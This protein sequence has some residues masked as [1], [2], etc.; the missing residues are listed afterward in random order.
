VTTDQHPYRS[1]AKRKKKKR[2]KSN[3]LVYAPEGEAKKIDPSRAAVKIFFV[4]S[5]IAAVVLLAGFVILSIVFF[6]VTS[7]VAWQRWRR[8]RGPNRDV[9]FQIEKGVLKVYSGGDYAPRIV[10]KVRHIRE[11]ALEESK[12]IERG[13]GDIGALDGLGGSSAATK[14]EES[15]ICIDDGERVTPVTDDRYPRLECVE[16][17]GRVRSFLRSHKWLPEDERAESEGEPDAS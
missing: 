16:W 4:G 2:D 9:V 15:R 17:L 13:G 12:T 1:P 11:V 5:A 10:A 6:L 14:A 8:P 7:A 3:E